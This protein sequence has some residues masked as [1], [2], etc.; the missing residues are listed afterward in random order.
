MRPT[1]AWPSVLAWSGDSSPERT[2][3]SI[4]YVMHLILHDIW[5]STHCILSWILGNVNLR[6]RSYSTRLHMDHREHEPVAG[7]IEMLSLTCICRRYS[8]APSIF[9]FYIHSCVRP[10]LLFITQISTCALR[11]FGILSLA[12]SVRAEWSVKKMACSSIEVPRIRLYTSFIT[13]SY[14]VL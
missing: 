14:D 13:Y 8:P 12:L 7:P 3:H 11:S 5:Q 1:W 4:H 10:S 2:R 6:C 9:W